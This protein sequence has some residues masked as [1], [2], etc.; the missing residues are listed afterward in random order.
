PF[1]DPSRRAEIWQRVFPAA[2]PT[3]ELDASR[4]A[5]LDVPGGT[6]RNIAL[7]AAFLAADADEPV[8][9]AHLAKAARSEVAKLERPV[10]AAEIGDG[11]R[12][13]AGSSCTAASPGC[14]RPR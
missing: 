10:T 12:R 7:S 4:L 3:A 11:T 8:R 5:R 14:P 1:P 6:I 2:T 13:P 9:M